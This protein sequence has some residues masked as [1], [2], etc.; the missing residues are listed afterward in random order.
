MGECRLRYDKKE[1]KFRIDKHP[2][3]WKKETEK[4]GERLS[5]FLQFILARLGSC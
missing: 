4:V 1:V 5:S 3:T 2:A